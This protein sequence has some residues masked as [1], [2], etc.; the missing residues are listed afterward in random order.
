MLTENLKNP[1]K[2]DNYFWKNDNIRISIS[3]VDS[4]S[5]PIEFEKNHYYKPSVHFYKNGNYQ[6]INLED[7]HHMILSMSEDYELINIYED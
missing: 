7:F 3:N 4:N 6:L 1:K 5:D 2:G